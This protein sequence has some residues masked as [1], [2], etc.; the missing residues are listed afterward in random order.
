MSEPAVALTDYAL[1]V[2]TAVL[3]MLLQRRQRSALQIWLIVYFAS[4]SVAS[5]LGGTVH[6]FV[7]HDR[8]LIRSMLWTAILLAIG[9]TALATWFIGA[10]LLVSRLVSRLV[11]IVAAVQFGAYTVVVLFVTNAFRTA[12]MVNLPAVLFLLAIIVIKYLRE[13]RRPLLLAASGLALSLVAALLQQF[14]VG[15]HPVHFD[16]NAV[17]HVIQAIALYLFYRGA[18]G[19]LE[20]QES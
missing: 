5:L 9:V 1:A 16:H 14:G 12:I 6:G 7:L 15:L 10:E 4:V 20:R 17:Y 8:P 19:L 13:G 3:A 11:R 18:V 2:E